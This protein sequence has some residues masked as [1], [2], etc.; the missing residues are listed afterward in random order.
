MIPK[1][2]DREIGASPVQRVDNARRGR[3][4]V[5][6]VFLIGAALFVRDVVFPPAQRFWEEEVVP[7]LAGEPPASAR[8]VPTPEEA[9]DPGRV[10]PVVHREE[11]L[12]ALQRPPPVA[13]RI[14]VRL[15]EGFRPGGFRVAAVSH[16]LPL[17]TAAPGGWRLPATTARPAFAVLALNDGRAYP[18]LLVREGGVHRLY[19]DRNR[20]GDL[21][22]DGAPLANEGGGGF[23]TTLRLPLAEVTGRPFEGT[24]D[25]WVYV[26]ERRDDRLQVYSRTQLSGEV[27]LGGR[28]YPAV[29]ADNLVL[30]GDFTNDG[31]AIDLDGDGRFRGPREVL[32]AGEALEL[33]GIAYRFDVTW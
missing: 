27:T 29:V 23:A 8:R 22:D 4:V 24:Y 12:E 18:I 14:P 33:S 2:P 20:N 6:L 9:A 28:S 13:K 10:P 16:V 17:T 11:L 25:L 7:R 30:D 15:A 31:I 3:L 19:L 26:D 32:R 21:T 5:L 1:R